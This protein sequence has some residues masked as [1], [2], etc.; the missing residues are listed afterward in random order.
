MTPNLMSER[1]LLRPYKE[2]DLSASVVLF[3]DPEVMKFVGDGVMSWPRATE[4]FRKVFGIYERGEFDV[5]AVCSR[6]D[7]RYI[8]SAELKPRR[9]AGDF[10]IVYILGKTHWGRGYATEVA[11][12]LIGYGFDKLHLDRVSATVDPDNIASVH[13]LEKLGFHPLGEE[14]DE[15]GTVLVYAVDNPRRPD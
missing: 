2:D 8:G 6:D 9:G 1:L 10:E 15:T 14:T 5:W 11:R 3:T 12:L 7:G 13:V 4:L